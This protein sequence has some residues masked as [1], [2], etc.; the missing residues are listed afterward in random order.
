MHTCVL[1]AA[2]AAAADSLSA[3]IIVVVVI[4]NLLLLL[5]LSFSH[6][7]VSVFSECSALSVV[8]VSTW[9]GV[10]VFFLFNFVNKKLLSHPDSDIRLIKVHQ[11]G[12]QTYACRLIVRYAL[13]GAIVLIW[14]SCRA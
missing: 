12:L 6:F 14:N 4:I 8:L 1:C 3:I 2:A 10:C 9:C 5:L 7:I 13:H 11:I